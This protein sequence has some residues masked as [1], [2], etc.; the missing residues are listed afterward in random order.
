LI[1]DYPQAK[2]KEIVLNKDSGEGLFG[3][4]ARL[5]YTATHSGDYFIIVGDALRKHVGGYFLAV[6]PVNEPLF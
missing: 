3:Q 6:T 1:V 2:A 5:T 4:D